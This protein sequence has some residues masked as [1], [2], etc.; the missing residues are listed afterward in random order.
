MNS[1]DKENLR[2]RLI[3]LA[4]KQLG[5]PYVYGAAPSAAP[6]IFDCSSLVQYLYEKIGFTLPRTTIEQARMGK[7]LR[8]PYRGKLKAG[9]IILLRGKVG[10]Y[11]RLYPQGIG[12][13]I[14]V[15]GPDEVIHAKFRKVGGRDAGE[16]K[17]QRLSTILKRKDITVVRRII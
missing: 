2:N 16:V 8:P 1:Q 6:R 7:R 13:V 14:L 12:H 15:T 10:R 4:E 3:E 9:D 5:R 17:R 11:D